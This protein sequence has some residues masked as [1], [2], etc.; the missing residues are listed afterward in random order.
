MAGTG[1]ERRV[2]L[3]FNYWAGVESHI[4]IAQLCSPFIALMSLHAYAEA[5]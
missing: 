1:V 5:T 4:C 2:V 3:L